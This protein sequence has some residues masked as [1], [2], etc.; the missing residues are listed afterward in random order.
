LGDSDHDEHK[1]KRYKRID[2]E[3]R[4]GFLAKGAYG[5][6]YIAED[7]H[8]GAVV[9]IKKQR[10]PS[11]EVARDLAFAKVIASSPSAIMIPFIFRFSSRGGG[12]CFECGGRCL[13]EEGAGSE[14]EQRPSAVQHKKAAALYSIGARC[15]DD[16]LLL[17]ARLR[18]GRP[19]CSEALLVF[20]LRLHGH[21][22]V[23]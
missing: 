2:E 12:G 15:E 1:S 8:T 13:G 5:K 21:H 6:V 4:D 7:T 22:V 18:G 20:G 19:N 11:D 10:Y 17:R 3:V 14:E 9:A 16:R 23:A